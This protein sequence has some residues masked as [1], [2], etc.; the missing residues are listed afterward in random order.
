MRGISNSLRC[1]SSYSTN[2]WILH[3]KENIFQCKEK[4][5]LI[6]K[7][8]DEETVTNMFYFQIWLASGGQG[9]ERSLALESKGHSIQLH[10]YLGINC[11]NWWRVFKSYYIRYR[12]KKPKHGGGL[13][14]NKSYYLSEFFKFLKPFTK[15]RL[16]VNIIFII[17]SSKFLFIIG[18]K[19]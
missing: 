6:P 17:F 5:S 3:E 13:C 1:I 10:I 11:R 18:N 7:K 15:S 4:M 8:N 9:S 12:N 2:C 16:W 14:G 19:S